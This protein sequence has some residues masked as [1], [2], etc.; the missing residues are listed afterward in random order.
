MALVYYSTLSL[1]ASKAPSIK[2]SWYTLS[3]RGKP[4][5]LYDPKT[6]DRVVYSNWSTGGDDGTTHLHTACIQYGEFKE[7]T[8]QAGMVSMIEHFRRG[9]K[10]FKEQ[11]M[12][13]PYADQDL[14]A[15]LKSFQET[16][17]TD[18]NVPPGNVRYIDE[19][20]AKQLTGSQ[21]TAEAH[22]SDL[23]VMTDKARQKQLHRIEFSDVKAQSK[24]SDCIDLA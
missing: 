7:S 3:Y 1:D 18:S 15:A 23:D 2:E 20:L 22:D 24:F 9:L 12:E 6:N 19:T 14:P 11:I 4:P 8:N 17:L 10:G 13:S 21:L 5:R 16:Q